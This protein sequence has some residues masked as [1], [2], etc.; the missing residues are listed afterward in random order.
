MRRP[1]TTDRPRWELDR[2]N[3]F[4]FAWGGD[5]TGS[6]VPDAMHTEYMG[7]P[8][9]AQ[10]ALV[11]A[12]TELGGQPAPPP[13]PP[14]PWLALPTMRRGTVSAAV[15]RWQRWYNAYPFRPALL[16]II[17]P[18]STVFGPQTEAA[19]KKVQVRY[20]LTADGIVGPNTNQVLWRL[21]WRG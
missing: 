10:A 19:V 13:A 1:V 6:S 8:D 5:Y 21:G 9:Q 14:A 4:G 17:S 11:L 2:W 20:G 3:R 15:Q 16:P 18:T 12:R 7:S